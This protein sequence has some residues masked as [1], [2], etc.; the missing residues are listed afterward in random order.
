MPWTPQTWPFL[1]Q[2]CSPNFPSI[3][4]VWRKAPFKLF[5]TQTSSSF[6]HSRN[7]CVLSF[8]E[9]FCQVRLKTRKIGFWSRCEK[10]CWS[11][12]EI[13]SSFSCSPQNSHVWRFDWQLFSRHATNNESSHEPQSNRDILERF[14]AFRNFDRE[15]LITSWGLIKNPQ[16]PVP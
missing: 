9:L 4:K 6:L 8:K 16:V 12:A 5:G 2:A 1:E 14:D 7:E 10:K 11:H 13:S 3:E 15:L